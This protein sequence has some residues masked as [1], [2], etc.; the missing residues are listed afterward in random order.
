MAVLDH[1]HQISA[2]DGHSA[3]GAGQFCLFWVGVFAVIALLG[4][5]F[6]G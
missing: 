4:F 6:K 5:L 1:D 2:H 3:G